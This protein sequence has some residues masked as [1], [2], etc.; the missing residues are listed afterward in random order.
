MISFGMPNDYVSPE[1]TR[2]ITLA[3]IM[4]CIYLFLLIERPWESVSFLQGFQIERMFAIVMI[5]VAIVQSRFRIVKSPTNKWVYG[6]LVLHI[7]LAPFAFNPGYALEQSTEYAKMV[8]IYMLMLAV[9]DDEMSLKILVK[10]FVFSMMFYMLHSLREYQN[11]RHFYRMG[12]T[13]MIGADSTLNDPNAFGASVVLSL[14]AVY[15]LLRTELSLLHRRLY[16]VYFAVSIFCVVLTGSRSASIALVFVSL[17][18]GA[19]QQG[20]RKYVVLAAVIF[21]I[22]IVWIN[23]PSEKQARIRTLWD[24]DAGPANAYQSADGR[25]LGLIAGWKMFL[26]VPL[27]G[28]GAGGKNFIGY[29]IT[30]KIDNEGEESPIQAHNLIGEVLA[31]LG[32]GG[33][34]FLVGLIVSVMSCCVTVMKQSGQSGALAPFPYYLSGAIVVSLLLLL[35]FGMSGHNFYRPMWL[36]LA[37]WAGSLVRLTSQDKTNQSTALM[38]NV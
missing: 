6:M 3:L 10:V 16:Y 36:W 38:G 11:G 4:V 8:I 37:A 14:P 15:A 33:A 26:Q 31:E 29:R 23:M 25:R 30:H 5:I 35:L 24:K 22:G 27:T 13:R 7:T 12:I 2:Q 34:F 18:W 19:L 32:I 1:P 9:V 20:A 21:S 28:V 17:L